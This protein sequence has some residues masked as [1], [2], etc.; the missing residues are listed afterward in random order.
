MFQWRYVAQTVWTMLTRPQ[1]LI[2]LPYGLEALTQNPAVLASEQH[3]QHM[4]NFY[5]PAG[6]LWQLRRFNRSAASQLQG[7]TQPIH[8]SIPLA[9]R[10]ICP[11]AMDRLFQQ[12]PFHP[13]HCCGRYEDLYHDVQLETQ[14]PAVVADVG[15]WAGQLSVAA[16]SAQSNASVPV[17]SVV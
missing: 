12:L 10:I 6:F 9:D 5:I 17:L 3:Q 14:M 16:G 1:T 2:Q 11:N 15:A 13:N 8:L 4:A 7:V